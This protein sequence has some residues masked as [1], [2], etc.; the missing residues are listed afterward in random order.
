MTDRPKQ[1]ARF[2]V[3]GGQRGEGAEGKEGG[4]PEDRV[5]EKF[6]RERMIWRSGDIIA[7]VWAPDQALP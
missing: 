4:S 6:K 7:S 3:K 5:T 1:G 2:S